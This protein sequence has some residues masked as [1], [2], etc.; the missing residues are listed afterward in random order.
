MTLKEDKQRIIILTAT[1][2]LV[3][4]FGISPAI[5]SAFAESDCSQRILI[6][7]AR[8]R[9]DQTNYDNR[10]GMKAKIKVSDIVTS[11]DCSPNNN[12]FALI[13]IW[14]VFPNLAWIET[15][16]AQ[17][18]IE[19]TCYTDEKEYLAWTGTSSHSTYHEEYVRDISLGDRI[20]Y[21]ISDTNQNKTWQVISDGQIRKNLVTAY[22]HGT[23]MIVG[24]EANDDA[25]SVPATTIKSIK[26]YDENSWHRWTDGSNSKD[27]DGWIIDCQKHKIKVGIGGKTEC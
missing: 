21:E 16:V 25:A 9:G 7:N 10:D 5:Q 17:G 23:K 15:G 27:L 19:G 11:S 12:G 4:T 1:V 22:S 13:G 26:Y 2:L 24:L 18:K 3:T 8:C 14:M 6:W 20:R